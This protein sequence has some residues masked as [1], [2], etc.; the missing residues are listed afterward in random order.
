MTKTIWLFIW[1]FQPVHLGHISAI[2]QLLERG[3]DRVVIGLGSSNAELSQENPFSAVEREELLRKSLD[4]HFPNHIIE[5]VE[6]PDVD[7]DKEWTEHILQTIQPSFIMSGNPWTRQCFADK[8]IEII[9]PSFDQKISATEIRSA[10][11]E[12]RLDV[13]KQFLD[14]H[15]LEF[16][17]NH[18]YNG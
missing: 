9:E 16:L 15:I 7:Q 4:L 13:V 3:V 18:T 5:I 17:D 8:G 12:G 10:W 14:N 2:E 11:R 1:R 6:I